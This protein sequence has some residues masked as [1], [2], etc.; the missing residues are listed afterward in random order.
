L[1]NKKVL[2]ITYYW[3]PAGGPGVQ[4]VLKFAKYLPEFGW[5]PII[6]TVK[7]G[8]YPAIDETLS[9]EIPSDCIVYKTVSLEPTSI[10]KTFLGLNRNQPL[11]TA[12]LSQAGGSWKK[13]LAHWIR[14]N[15][16][17]PDAKIGW[18]PLAVKH[19]KKIIRQYQP[20]IIFSSSPP[21]TVNL[22][23]QRLA[24]WS[25]LKWVADFRDP[26]TDIYYL[27]LA[28]KNAIVKKIEKRLEKAVLNAADQVTTVSE[29]LAFQFKQGIKNQQKFSIIP[30]GYDEEDFVNIKREIQRDKFI[31]AYSGKM[32]IQQNP[33]N[34]WKALQKLTETMPAFAKDFRF[35][36]I[37]KMSPEILADI[38]ENN[39]LN[40]LIDKGYMAHRDA[41]QSLASAAILLLVIPRSRSNKGILTGKLFEYLAL[42][43]FILNIGPKDG[44]AAKIIRNAKCGN[45]YD[46]EDELQDVILQLYNNWQ[47]NIS[48]E[49]DKQSI[50]CFTRRN[51]AKELA[52]IFNKTIL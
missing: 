24:K 51:I 11:P 32:T 25:G 10:Y 22:I 1:A 36:L 23:A 9:A 50:N 48:F 39:L 8:E 28:A 49:P 20:D 17:I 47:A 16:F 38:K 14:L 30:N 43:R 41:L 13:R 42:Q 40:F 52:G 15:L 44:D 37:G 45:T 34:L 18:L 19:G 12:V 35:H 6:L 21:P 3:P 2:I 5:Q 7:H 29:D 26:W 4:R 31:I 46:F 27:D 33:K